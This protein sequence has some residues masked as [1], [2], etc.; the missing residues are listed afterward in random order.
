MGQA[1]NRGCRAPDD[2]SQCN[3]QPPV[4]TIRVARDRKGRQSIEGSE[5]Q[6]GQQSQLAIIKTELVLD[7]IL[8]KSENLAVDIAQYRNQKEQ[9]KCDVATDRGNIIVHQTLNS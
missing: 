7:I 8:E 5:R 2:D 3:H 6:T 9:G 4:A 1:A